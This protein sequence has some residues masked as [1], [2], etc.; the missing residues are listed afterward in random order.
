MKQSF[1]HA[2]CVSLKGKGILI[3]GKPGTGKSSLA[4]HLIDRGARLV[5]DDQTCLIS[6]GKSLIALAPAMHKGKIEVR[7][8]GICVFPYEN[9]VPL[10]LWVELCEKKDVERLPGPSFIEYNT[11]KVLLLK[12]NENDPLGA[13]KVELKVES[14][15]SSLLK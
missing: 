1:L 3:S 9:K 6:E 12:L 5:S 14:Y 15:G 10:S 4:L 8:V 7:N 13:M 11:I 2:T